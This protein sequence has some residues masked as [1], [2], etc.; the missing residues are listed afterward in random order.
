MN[1]DRYYSLSELRQVLLVGSA[2]EEATEPGRE[3][4]YY[5]NLHQSPVERML[6]MTRVSPS[7]SQLSQLPC[8][9]SLG[10]D[11]FQSLALRR[12]KD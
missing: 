1:F 7:V 10:L 9:G 5:W 12:V 11:P 6:M 8:L 3:N 4:A 2:D